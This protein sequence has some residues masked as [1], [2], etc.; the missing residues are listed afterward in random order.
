MGRTLSGRHLV[1]RGNPNRSVFEGRRAEQDIYEATQMVALDALPDALPE[2]VF[3]ILAPLYELF[4]FFR[5]PKRLDWAR[6]QRPAPS[7]MNRSRCLP[8]RKFLVRW[9]EVSA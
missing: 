1:S 5:L 7:F 8:A 9:I 3:A 2:L 6:A 4:D